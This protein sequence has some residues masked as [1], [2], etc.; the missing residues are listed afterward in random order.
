MELKE[1]YDNR[2]D[3]WNLGVT[4]YILLSK[5]FPFVDGAAITDK[6][7]VFGKAFDNVSKDAK[8]FIS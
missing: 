5:E 7:L 8:D 4:A 6:P 2:V 3:V 1:E